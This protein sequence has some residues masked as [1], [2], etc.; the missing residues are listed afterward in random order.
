MGADPAFVASPSSRQVVS[1]EGFN[2]GEDT[3]CHARSDLQYIDGLEAHLD[4]GGLTSSSNIRDLIAMV[5]WNAGLVI[6]AF[7]AT[8]TQSTG[9]TK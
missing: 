1:T 2:P 7:A 8:S 4:E 5:R 3:A 6:E 9:E